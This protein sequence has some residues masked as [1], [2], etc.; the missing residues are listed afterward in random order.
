MGNISGKK[1]KATW[2][3]PRTGKIQYI[4]SFANNG[5]HEFDPHGEV[6]DGNDWILIFD[7]I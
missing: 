4:G 7:S 3:N 1:V 6:V 2:Y 5:T